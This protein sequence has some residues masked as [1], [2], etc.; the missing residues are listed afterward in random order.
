MITYKFGETVIN[1]VSI[2]KITYK[3]DEIT[4]V[5]TFSRSFEHYCNNISFVIKS[6][7]KCITFI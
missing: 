1:H 6:G 2:L 5:I 4:I 3:F 7:I